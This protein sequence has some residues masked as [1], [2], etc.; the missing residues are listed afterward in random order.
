MGQV[1]LPPRVGTNKI[2]LEGYDHLTWRYK[3][4]PYIRTDNCIDMSNMFSGE[5][6]QLPETLDLRRFNTSKV[7]DMRAMFDHCMSTSILGLENFDTSKVTDMSFM[8]NEAKAT[9]VSAANFDTSKVTTME[10]M[11]CN[12][13][14]TELDVSGFDTHLVTNM[15]CIFEGVPSELDV[16]GFDTALVTTMHNM[17]KGTTSQTLDVS[18]FNTSQVTNMSG[19]FSGAHCD[20]IDVSSFD[21]SQVTDMNR[22]FSGISL[23]ELDIS[24]FDISNVEDMSYMFAG[25]TFGSIVPP[26][27]LDLSKVE[28]IEYL[29]RRLTIPSLDL[30]EWDFT[31][32]TNRKYLFAGLK[33]NTLDLSTWDLGEHV[34]DNACCSGTWER[35]DYYYI[36]NYGSPEYLFDSVK[37]DNLIFSDSNTFPEF[38]NAS[39]MFG[40]IHVNGTLDLSNFHFNKAVIYYSGTLFGNAKIDTLILPDINP[41]A[42]LRSNSSNGLRFFGGATVEL[43]DMSNATI[44]IGDLNGLHLDR[45][46]P[47][48]G[49][50]ATRINM[51]NFIPLRNKMNTY[52][53]EYVSGSM[54]KYVDYSAV[55]TIDKGYD[56][57]Q[58][59]DI[60]RYC[61]NR[62][63]IVWIPSTFKLDG[64]HDMYTLG[65][66]VYTD[67]PNSEALGWQSLKIGPNIHYNATHEDFEQAI[68]EDNAHEWLSPRGNSIFFCHTHVPLGSTMTPSQFEANYGTVYLDGEPIEVNGYTFNEVGEHE[69]KITYN[70][71]DFY[72]TIYVD[73]HGTEYVETYPSIAKY[74]ATYDSSARYYK[75]VK[76]NASPLKCRFYSD[77][78]L[79]VWPCQ[80]ITNTINEYYRVESPIRTD[81]VKVS[82]IPFN[83]GQFSLQ[84]C[85][86]LTDISEL[87]VC[88]SGQGGFD[89][90]YMFYNCTALE[91][92]SA[93]DKWNINSTAYLY[94]TSGSSSRREEFYRPTGMFGYTPIKSAPAMAI[95]TNTSWIFYNCSEL[96]DISKI[97]G[98]GVSDDNSYYSYYASYTD[99]FQNCTKLSDVSH[100]YVLLQNLMVRKDNYSTLLANKGIRFYGFLRNTAITNTDFFPEGFPLQAIDNMFLD[101]QQLTDLTG[102]GRARWTS[103]GTSLYNP[104]YGIAAT[105]Y[106]PLGNWNGHFES[107]QMQGCKMSNLDF[108]QNW[109]MSKCTNYD[110]RNCSNLTSMSALKNKIC[111][112]SD[113]MITLTYCSSLISLDGLQG[114]TY[115]SIHCE[116]CTSLQSCNGLQGATIKNANSLFSS[117]TS[118]TDLSALAE[119]NFQISGAAMDSMFNR[120]TSLTSLNGLQNLDISNITSLNNVFCEC[121]SLTDISAI[122]RW[123]PYQVKTINYLFYKC[124][125]ITSFAALSEWV[126]GQLTNAT[127]T[128][129]ECS[130]LQNLNGLN[131]IN[132]GQCTTLQYL[133]DGCTSLTNI[134]GIM[135]WY[136][137]SCTNFSGMFRNCT[138]L[139]SIAPIR[140]WMLTKANNITYMFSGDVAITDAELLNSW[141]DYKTMT[142]V[143]RTY[144]FKN[145]PKPWPTWAVS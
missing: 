102:L 116:G 3:I 30:R 20:E 123:N 53:E 16:S 139:T 94:G 79:F 136:V 67:A 27:N 11:F 63:K 28:N 17:F 111:T 43:L 130:S 48:T 109:D 80:D 71:Y 137:G 120:C 49:L 59:N 86:Q 4:I 2:T 8:F 110:F 126:T 22:M 72:Q 75:Y 47:F 90:S 133:F 57:K 145:V 13:P 141:S 113:I 144:A 112:T 54:A 97:T 66:Q 24:N 82:G 9:N 106:S 36:N 104:F 50:I 46:Y 85:R 114:G 44:D 91:D 143:S 19:M 138:S 140:Y 108:M 34:S 128:F 103:N 6:Y 58:Y 56:E 87:I 12:C 95:P 76:S 117:C 29:F 96:V 84:G 115:S 15:S 45:F 32:T 35:P 118:L 21:T 5:N 42:F 1:L 23:E 60:S 14:T 51:P 83:L 10:N 77:G 68:L 25:S 92:V 129:R 70:N 33:T 100:L 62:A 64:K 135:L 31:A 26:Q 132:I 125:S 101:C 52:P 39:N 127:Y 69:L 119:A 134:D 98:F 40:G 73:D 65:D 122:A 121:T 105:D 7:T 74:T 78:Y 55:N 142:S 61:I 124:S 99:V 89:R 107:I 131:G 38:Y 18:H 81:V 37:V 93:V 41:E 88:T